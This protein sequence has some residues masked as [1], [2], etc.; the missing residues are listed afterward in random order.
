MKYWKRIMLNSIPVIFYQQGYTY[1][2]TGMQKTIFLVKKKD[3]RYTRM[4]GKMVRKKKY[5][6]GKSL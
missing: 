6:I 5:C 2:E 1:R 3:A 4:Q